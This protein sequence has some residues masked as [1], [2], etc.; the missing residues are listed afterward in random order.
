MAVVDTVRDRLLA[1][2]RLAG[3]CIDV[4]PCDGYCALIGCVDTDDQRELA[5]EL[6]GGISGV[7]K[8]ENYLLVRKQVCG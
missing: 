6:A 7:G 2:T 3:Q 8:T 1:D 5:S 4:M